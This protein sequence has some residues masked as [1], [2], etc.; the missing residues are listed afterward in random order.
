MIQWRNFN[1]DP[2]F[3]LHKLNIPPDDETIGILN[4]MRRLRE[5]YPAL[6]FG[7]FNP[8]RERMLN[9]EVDFAH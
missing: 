5:K 6:K 4:L 2:D 7:Y 3:Y 9:Y 1:I 8:P